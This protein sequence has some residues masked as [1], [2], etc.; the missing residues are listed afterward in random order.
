MSNLWIQ[1]QIVQ[2]I[3]TSSDSLSR[4]RWEVI[5]KRFGSWLRVFALLVFGG[6]YSDVPF[7]RKTLSQCKSFSSE[8][9]GTIQSSGCW[10]E[11]TDYFSTYIM[12]IQSLDHKHLIP[13]Q[14]DQVG[15]FLAWPFCSL[16]NSFKVFVTGFYENCHTEHT[17]AVLLIS[18]FIK[19]FL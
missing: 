2:S 4:I 17:T 1:G 13:V 6:Y 3:Y 5:V 12:S 18:G 10:H 9:V 19:A 14:L 8:T 15:S 11:R 7:N 16:Q